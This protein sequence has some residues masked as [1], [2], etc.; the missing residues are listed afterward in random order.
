MARKKVFI[1]REIPDEGIKLLKKKRYNVV[2]APQDKPISKSKLLQSVA[3]ADALLSILTDKIDEKVFK[4]GKNLQIVANYAVGFN[5]IDTQAAEKH[6]IIVTNTPVPE[7]SESVAEHTIALILGL[8]HRIVETDSFTR[9]GKYKGWGP[10]MFLGSDIMGKTLGIVGLG[11]IG[12]AVARRLHDGFGL[13]ILYYNRSKNKAFERETGAKYVSLNKLMKESDYV[14]VHLPLLPSTHHFIST[15]EIKLM[16]KTAFLINTARGPI[17]DELALTK[18]LSRGEIGGAGLDVYECEPFIDC[19]PDDQYELRK[20]SNVIL[21]PHTASATIETRQA[22][23][24]MAAKN[25]I[26][27]LEGKKPLSP[28]SK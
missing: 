15:K 3:D 18:A 14:T 26:A 10:M 1:T 16:K 12:R 6:N 11:S 13:K 24:V 21:T 27:V 25:I 20:L 7:V 22:M 23:S 28:V 17:V 5:N 9:A 8:A 19:N 2:V 4:A